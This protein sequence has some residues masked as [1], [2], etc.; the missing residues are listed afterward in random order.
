MDANE[1]ARRYRAR[2]RGESVPLIKPGPK[3]GYQQSLA[4]AAKRA[5]WGPEHHA[6][7]GKAVSDRIG[8]KRALRRFRLGPCERCG[9]RGFDR[10][11]K[12]R[13]PVNNARSNVEI[14]CRRCHAR[15]HR[16]PRRR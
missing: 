16:A 14:L 1:R 7:K 3:P 5:R 12:D 10:H 13:N 8:R 4:H 9:A 15:E 11:H 2:K 6:W